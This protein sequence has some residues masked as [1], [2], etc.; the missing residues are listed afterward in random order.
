MFDLSHSHPHRPLNYS[1]LIQVRATSRSSL[2]LGA[3]LGTA[4][5]DL[6]RLRAADVV[7]RNPV[8][9]VG[10]GGR[11]SR[12]GGLLRRASGLALGGALGVVGLGALAL[13]GEV[14]SD[15]D[16]VEEVHDTNKAG[17]EE[18]VEED[19]IVPIVS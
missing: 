6:P 2:N 17:Q 10:G 5:L 15:P 14:G 11:N 13:L 12:A 18:E 3:D 19:A 4:T 9:V 16:S 7:R 8:G 1:P